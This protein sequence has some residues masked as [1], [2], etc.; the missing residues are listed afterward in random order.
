M[1]HVF[2]TLLGTA[3][4]HTTAARRRH[5]LKKAVLAFTATLRR[6]VRAT[7]FIATHADDGVVAV[8]VKVFAV[9]G[10]VDAEVRCCWSIVDDD[11]LAG[12]DGWHAEECPVL[13][14]R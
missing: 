11:T 4:Q 13:R 9:D 10:G 12:V 8:N 5:T 7:T 3:L 1:R 2:A 6:L 14:L